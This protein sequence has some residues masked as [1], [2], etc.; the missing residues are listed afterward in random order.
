M[1]ILIP[2]D[3]SE[4]A[5]AGLDMASEIP[6][7]DDI[8][9]L[10]IPEE[11]ITPAITEKLE[12]RCR[13]LRSTDIRTRYRIVARSQGKIADMIRSV[14]EEERINTIVVGA[15]GRGRI[16]KYFL[17]SVSD[18]LLLHV[19]RDLLIMRYIR[20]RMHDDR[21]GLFSRI[22]V[23]I[24]LSTI[25]YEILAFIRSLGLSS[26]VLLLHVVRSDDPALLD[27][28]RDRLNDAADLLKGDAGGPSVSVLLRR[29]NRI[30]SILSVAESHAM[31]IIVIARFGHLDYLKKAII[32]ETV[33][34]VAARADIPVYIRYPEIN[35]RVDARELNADEFIHA[36][37]LWK[38]YHQQTGDPASDR[39]FGTFA[40]GILVAV[41]RCRRHPDGDEVDAVFTPEGYRGHGFARHAV[42]ALIEACRDNYLY[43]HSTIA[44][45]AFYRRYGFVEIP[46]EELPPSIRRRYAF[47]LGNLKGAGVVP[48]MRSPD[49]SE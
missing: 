18:D 5:D 7:V 15:R 37:E 13:R 47:A 3:C 36:E 29:G 42:G 34:G 2:T 25:S 33:A 40:E 10:H 4:Y 11:E 16:E 19:S 23:P 48:M 46:E 43:M 41:A 49:E 20:G 45:V 21:P 22:L 14:A 39:I 9:L 1:R 8:L 17:G 12:E 30:E 35:L 32:G 27:D 38:R 44:L 24:E 26:H 31:S 28:A 6:G